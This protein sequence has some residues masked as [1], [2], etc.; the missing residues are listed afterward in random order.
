MRVRAAPRPALADTVRRL[1]PGRGGALRRLPGWAPA[2]PRTNVRPVR[3]PT[4]WPVSRCSECAGRRVG[5]ATARAAVA[6]D[7]HTRPLVAAWKERGLRCLTAV[8]ADLVAEVVRPPPVLALA[9][10]PADRDRTLWRAR[11]RP[12]SLTQAL[13]ERWHLPFLPVSRARQ[14]PRQRGL[15]RAARRQNV[16]EAFR[17]AVRS[18][19]GSGSSTTSTRPARPCWPP[20]RSSPGRRPRSARRHVRAG[21]PALRTRDSAID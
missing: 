2:D 7:E 14:T 11:A 5:F 16:R 13:S 20:R 4:A 15:D 12:R 1:W 18:R 10:V 19:P 8:A 17:S 6:Y 3:A 21:D 9:P